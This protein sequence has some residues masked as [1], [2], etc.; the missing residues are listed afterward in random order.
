MLRRVWACSSEKD[1]REHLRGEDAQE[2]G[3]RIDGGVGD[4]RRVGAGDV[5]GEG[6]R[7][8]IGHAAGEQ[9]AEVHEVH[10]PDDAREDADEQERQ[11]GDARAGEQPLQAGGA[12]DGGEEFCARAE[13][14]G[15]EEKR[16]AE[17][18]EGEIGIHRHVP[19]LPPDAADAA[20]DERDDERA[21]GEAEPDRLRQAGEGDRH[22]C[23]AR[24]RGRCR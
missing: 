21:A 15:G 18:A 14:D 23:R 12:E 4:G 2:R 5:R 3:E 24:C 11:H 1:D 13:A 22:A 6:E 19:D 10:L 8:R 16:D 17:F 20:E 7:G 9:A